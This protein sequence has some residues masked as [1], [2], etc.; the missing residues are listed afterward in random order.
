M[1][2]RL[3]I[4][5]IWS[6]FSVYAAPINSQICDGC[7]RWSVVRPSYF[8]RLGLADLPLSFIVTRAVSAIAELLVKTFVEITVLS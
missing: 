4:S 8:I 2:R 5:F 6:S 1:K 7:Q 3:F